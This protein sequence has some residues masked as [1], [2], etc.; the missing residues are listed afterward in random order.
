MRALS[1]AKLSYASQLARLVWRFN[2][3]VDKALIAYREP[4]ME[5]QLIQERIAN[6]AMELFAATCVLSRWDSELMAVGRNGSESVDHIAADLFIRHSF[7]KTRDCLRGLGDN[8]DKAMLQT[9]DAFLGK[10]SSPGNN[11][12]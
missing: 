9:A 11:G 1:T 5:M 10:K 6:A 7:R 12:A 8:D 2:F 4:V 3:A